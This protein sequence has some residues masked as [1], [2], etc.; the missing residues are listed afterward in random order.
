MN[1][2]DDVTVMAQ[3]LSQTMGEAQAAR[4]RIEKLTELL[5]R[6]RDATGG[7]PT[8]TGLVEQ[9]SRALADFDHSLIDLVS[10]LRQLQSQSPVKPGL[11][12]PLNAPPAKERILVIDDE[13]SV[14][15]LVTRILKARGYEVDSAGDGYTA[16]RMV[17][18]QFY[19]L[20]MADLKMPEIGGMDVYSRIE[21]SNPMQ[22]RRVVFFSGD[23]VN[24]QTTAFLNRVGL[25]FLVKPF[26][27]KELVDFVEQAL[28]SD[29]LS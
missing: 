26:T 28:A 3:L 25:P 19:D 17:D 11:T 5:H 12:T 9:M 16:I 6:L 2:M 4:V 14:V 27:I 1:E 7:D 24:P 13:R 23:V 21:H 22:A 29:E 10:H 18:A 8:A 20:I 15:E